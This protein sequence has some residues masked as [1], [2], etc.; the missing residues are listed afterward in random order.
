MLQCK[1]T[2][3]ICKLQ[4]FTDRVMKSVKSCSKSLPLFYDQLAQ[5]IAETESIDAN[6]VRTI[7]NRIED[8]FVNTYMTDKIQQK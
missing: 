1:Y 2:T 5:I 4:L 7:S 3:I 6:F 8:E